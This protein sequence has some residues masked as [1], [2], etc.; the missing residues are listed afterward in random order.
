MTSTDIWKYFH[1]VLDPAGLPA[2]KCKGCRTVF[3][4]PGSYGNTFSTT[5]LIR[6]TNL[7]LNLKRHKQSSSSTSGSDISKWFEQQN[8]KDSSHSNPITEA[9]VKDAILKFFISG[10]IPFNQADNPEFRKLVQMI[11][12]NGDSV[13]INRKNI[14]ARLTEQAARA[15]EELKQELASNTSRISLA[16]DGWTSRLNN[17]YLGMNPPCRVQK[18]TLN[19]L[20]FDFVCYKQLC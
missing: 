7:C 18:R 3:K 6:H 14:R 2:A 8:Q 17:S 1:E 4:H 5:A 10:N 9:D 15:K 12:V 19:I 11:K 13:T 16:M 20:S